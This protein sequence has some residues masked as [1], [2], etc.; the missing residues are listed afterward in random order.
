MPTCA[1]CMRAGQ[2]CVYSTEDGRKKAV[3]KHY[4]ASLEQQVVSLE[5][6]L[7]RVRS[8]GSGIAKAPVFNTLALRDELR[9][10]TQEQA[11]SAPSENDSRD[12]ARAGK[13]LISSAS[14]RPF[15]S[16]QGP[17]SIYRLGGVCEHND[18]PDPAQHHTVPSLYCTISVEEPAV[19]G[20]LRS[21][22]RWQYHEYAFIY[23]EAFLLDYLNHEYQGRYCSLALVYA[24]C[25]LGCIPTKDKDMDS[26]KRFM[27]KAY[28]GLQSL[29]AL[30]I[31]STTVQALLSLAF[32]ELSLG[33][34]SK[35][36]LL[37]GGSTAKC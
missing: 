2:Q 29:E 9:E 5:D 11:D 33:N 17:T 30:H 26:M 16:Y 35:V 21:F 34:I 20:I 37:S 4:V 12:K 13:L 14:Q 7:R 36:W 27:E 10:T 18:A 3:S 32:C 23:R 28:S 1:N 25:A 22:F 8:D 31:D 15:V 24:I 6:A 19:D